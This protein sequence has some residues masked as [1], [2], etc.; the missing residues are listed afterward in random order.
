LDRIRPYMVGRAR[1]YSVSPFTPSA[2]LAKRAQTM[3]LRLDEF[4][5]NSLG[6]DTRTGYIQVI[7]KRQRSSGSW[8]TLRE[9][10]R[11][12]KRDEGEATK[13]P[14]AALTKRGRRRGTTVNGKFK[15]ARTPAKTDRPRTCGTWKARPY[16]HR[17]TDLLDRPIARH[18]K[19]PTPSRPSCPPST[20]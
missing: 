15:K 9:H 13:C 4:E 12:G 1:Q 18:P 5:R 17:R 11:G 6:T 20:P 7:Q 8:A 16:G 14:N 19:L 10:I 3:R 2:V